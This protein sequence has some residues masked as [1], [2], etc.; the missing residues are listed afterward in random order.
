MTASI[1]RKV[2]HFLHKPAV[3]DAAL[4]DR[5]NEVLEKLVE[6]KTNRQIGEELFISPNTV[7]YHVKQIYEKL[8]VHSRAEAVA[9]AMK[10]RR[11]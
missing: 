9:K 4:T 1:A 10:R 2:V 5:E 8:H 11:P 3:R 7:A 6:G